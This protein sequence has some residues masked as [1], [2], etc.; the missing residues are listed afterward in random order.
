[1]SLEDFLKSIALDGPPVSPPSSPP[2]S[3]KTLHP[4][5]ALRQFL[6]QSLGDLPDAVSSSFAVKKFMETSRVR[7]NLSSCLHIP[8]GFELLSMPVDFLPGLSF[9]FPFLIIYIKQRFT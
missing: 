7:A 2:S 8:S 4:S 6:Q 5:V 3:P 9:L 1:M